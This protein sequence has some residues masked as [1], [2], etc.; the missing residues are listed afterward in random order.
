[1]E[2]IQDLLIAIALGLLVG[3][4]REWSKS[5][6]AGVRTF[7]LITAFGTLASALGGGGGVAL[8]AAGLL[9]VAA[10][11]AIG[12]LG[13]QKKGAGDSGLTTEFASL[14]MFLV[15]AAVASGF[16][17]AATVMTGSVAVLLHWKAELHTFVRHLDEAE[18]R[19]GAR[20]VLLALVVLPALPNQDYGPYGV[21]NP[22]KIWLMVVLIVGISLAAYAASRMLGV[23]SATLLSGVL[24]GLVSSTATTVTYARKASLNPGVV[25]VSTTVIVT[26]SAVV[27]A[28]VL[29]EVALVAPGTLAATAPPLGL[30]MALLLA[31]AWLSR[32]RAEAQ[33]SAPSD[34]EPPSTVRIAIGFGVLYVAV[35]L[36]VAVSREH[37]GSGALYTVAALSGL[38]DVD[39]ITLSTTQL[40]ASGRLAQEQGWRLILVGALS[41]LAFKAAIAGALGPSALARSLLGFFGVALAGGVALLVWW[42]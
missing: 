16:I 14:V 21:L 10:M 35:L 9:V 19:S 27:F 25:G 36:A 40:V 2:L 23:R 5:K 37:L 39:A 33:E 15:G 1:M 4:Q 7:P 30:M 18:L 6:L 31:L 13:L 34:L 11:L 41:N 17:A 26:A 32:L 3:L 12:N 29:F 28:R 42:P 24:G 8:V 22:F 20:L 38:T